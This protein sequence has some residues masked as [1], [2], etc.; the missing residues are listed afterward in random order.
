MQCFYL[1]AYLPNGCTRISL[2]NRKLKQFSESLLQRDSLF[3][4]CPLPLESASCML[5]R[6]RN[7][8]NTVELAISDNATCGFLI[9]L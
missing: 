8:Q 4:K 5:D 6:A 2:K 9:I 7:V 3:N 1:F